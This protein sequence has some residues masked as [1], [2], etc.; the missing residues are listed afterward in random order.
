MSKEDFDR[1]LALLGGFLNLDRKQRQAISDELRDHLEMRVESLIRAGID[2]SAAQKQALEEFGDAAGV[3]ARFASLAQQR[4]R[5]R[6]MRIAS[7]STLLAI[8][9][10]ICTILLWPESNNPRINAPAAAAQQ[11]NTDVNAVG[12]E[13]ITASE[14]VREPRDNV[15]VTSSNAKD[16][17]TEKVLEFVVSVEGGS[18]FQDTLNKLSK[19]G[20]GL[21]YIV[22]ISAEDT[23][24]YDTEIDEKFNLRK[25]S[26][27]S[28][29]DLLLEKYD[30][31]FTIKDG[32]I[33]ILSVDEAESAEQQVTRVFYVKDILD[34]M[35][36]ADV[37]K[38]WNAGGNLGSSTSGGGLF[39]LQD[40]KQPM[41][42]GAAGVNGG[43]SGPKS[44]RA[45][46][47]KQVTEVDVLCN[48]VQVMVLP[49]R[50]E[51]NGGTGCLFLIGDS[52]AVR[53]DY[54]TVR[55]VRSFLNDLRVNLGIEPE[56]N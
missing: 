8:P 53:A 26:L 16:L 39:C 1:F 42:A 19:D 34:A 13:P 7:I 2:E 5:R 47:N 18:T 33:V 20:G 29:L 11:E 45:S 36:K 51:P 31:T 4:N 46:T 32:M 56:N 24:T 50:W 44:P 25:V 35:K 23:I 38:R 3:A 22:H 17:A 30:C 55:K 15:G 40:N 27:K 49:D 54:M 6:M 37:A 52:L 21:Q 41:T 9:M 14:L 28:A 43:S 48:A 12:S 10:V